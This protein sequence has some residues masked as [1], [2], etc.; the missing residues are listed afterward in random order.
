MTTQDHQRVAVESQVAPDALVVAP[1][2]C[3]EHYLAV[4]G[5]S[6]RN[7]LAGHTVLLVAPLSDRVFSRLKI[8]CREFAEKHQKSA[9]LREGN[10]NRGNCQ[11]LLRLWTH[12]QSGDPPQLLGSPPPPPPNLAKGGKHHN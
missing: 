6:Y 5:P 1:F 7:R 11:P 12:Q 8:V 3:G 2:D 9:C 10:G 4:G